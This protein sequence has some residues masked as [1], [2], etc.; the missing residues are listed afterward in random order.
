[1]KRRAAAILA[2]LALAQG[3][4]QPAEEE[5]AAELGPP[6]SVPDDFPPL[7]V[8]D[9]NEPTAARVALGRTLFY[10]ERLSRTEEV[11]CASCHVQQYA[12]AD[13]NRVSSG[14]EQR[15]GTRNA[16]A[17]VNMAYDTSFFWH[18]GVPSL[19]LQALGPIK[20]PL[21]MDMALA[22]VAE[23][24]SADPAIA[25]AFDEAYGE[26]PS[27]F[28][29]SRAVAS[30]VRSLISGQS[31]F[32]RYQRGELEALSEGALRGK[33]I[34]EDERGECF[35][36]HVGFNFTNN[37]F[38]N[39][40]IAASDPDIGRAEITNKTSDE[41]KFKVPTLRNVGVSA[42]YMHDGSLATLEDVIEHYDQGG[43]GHVNTDPTVQPL[44]LT[45]ADK[46]DLV[47]FLH[48]LT[49]QAFLTDSR[50]ADPEP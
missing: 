6:I 38:R 37:G 17:L 25:R 29:I 27:E 30:F 3:C 20:N 1:M 36:C 49:D 33:A 18:G 24:L 7:P 13:P 31:P 10:D 50:Y 34:F 16:P 44:E 2:S 22:D 39:N 14:V 46:A 23:R 35:H 47:E 9:D 40:G 11:S 15:T 32:D 4:S 8:P 19:E 28:T 45:D 42:P 43:R 5:P 12:F 41:G 26:P 21:E 48:A